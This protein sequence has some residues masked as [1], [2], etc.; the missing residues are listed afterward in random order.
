VDGIG[1]DAVNSL[2]GRVKEGRDG[3]AVK[4]LHKGALKIRE[5]A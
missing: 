1:R 5:S 4:R 2:L 3:E